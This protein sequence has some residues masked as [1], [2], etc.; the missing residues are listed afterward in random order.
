MLCPYSTST[1]SYLHLLHPPPRSAWT[2]RSLHASATNQV[3]ESKNNSRSICDKASSKSCFLKA[4]FSNSA[5]TLAW[6]VWTKAACS[7]SRCC[8]SCRTHESKTDL[9]SALTADSW[10][11][12]KFS[13]SRELVSRATAYSCSVRGTTSL[14]WLTESIR[15]V[16]ALVCSERAEFRIP[17]IRYL[18]SSGS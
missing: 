4:G 7:A 5:S 9:S 13:C 17:L 11:R 2:W 3:S 1:L 18:V 14:S 10:A 6:I 8:C 12:R 15:S 16:T